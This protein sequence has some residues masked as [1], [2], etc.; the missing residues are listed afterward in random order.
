MSTSLLSVSSFRIYI[1][2]SYF[3]FFFLNDPATPEF[4]PLPLH[5]ALPISVRAALAGLGAAPETAVFIGASRHDIECGRAA[6]VKTAA[7]L[8]GPFDRS[9]LADLAPDY[10]LERPEDLSLLTTDN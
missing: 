2:I 9:H 4:Y 1:H 10:W 5:D 7:V 6:R 3:F 8:W